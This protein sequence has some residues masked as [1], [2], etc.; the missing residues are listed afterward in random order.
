MSTK[1][2]NPYVKQRLEERAAHVSVIESI[3]RTA[4]DESRELSD[5]ERST[6]ETRAAAIEK[7]DGDLEFSARHIAANEK[8]Y[9]LVGAREEAKERDERAAFY[10]G[11]ETTAVASLGKTFTDSAEFRSYRGKGTTKPVELPGPASVEFR[12]AI[13]TGDAEQVVSGTWTGPSGPSRTTALLDAVTRVPVTGRFADYL[14][15]GPDP[16]AAEVPEGELKPE[17]AISPTEERAEVVTYAHWKAITRQALDDIPGVQTVLQGKLLGGV[18]KKLESAIAAALVADADIAAVTGPD[19]TTGIRL[20]LAQ[21]EADGFTASAVIVNPSDAAT[22]DLEQLGNTV[23]GAVRS[24]SSWGVPIVASSAVPAGSAYVID[25][26]AVTWFDRGTTD[27]YLSD[28]HEDYFVR[29]MLVILAEARAALVVTEPGAAVKVTVA[30]PEPLATK[31][32]KA[33]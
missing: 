26:Q 21:M 23:N 33:A 29:N 4:A 1:T 28:S 10:E 18:A 8:W 14:R 16:E 2:T 9:R 25:R 7:I 24:T 27:V 15:W 30:E 6:L 17:A 11:V 20:A 13:T 12:A 22:L 5:E 19:M 31:A 32:T 3:Q